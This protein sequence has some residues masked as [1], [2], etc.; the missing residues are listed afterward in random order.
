MHGKRFDIQFLRGVAVLAV[1][2][3]HA[4]KETFSRGFLGVDVFFV[5]SGFLITG[6]VLRG[7]EQG[8]FSFREFYLRRARRLLPASFA[9]LAVTTVLSV[10]LLTPAD[11][12]DYAKQLIGALTF[13]AN[14]VLAKQTGYFAAQAESK[15]LLHIWSLSLE[16]QFYFVAPLLLWL[17]PRRAWPWL[18]VC[19]AAGSAAGYFLLMGNS[20]LLGLRPNSAAKFAFFMLPTR[21]WELL[22]GSVVAWAMM[23]RP[24]AEAPVFA[25]YAALV[26]ICGTMLLGGRV[27]GPAGLEALLVTIAT[28]VTLVGGGEWLGRNKLTTSVAKIGDWSYS[29]YLVH[30]PLFAF[31]FILYLGDSPPVLLSLGLVLLSILLGWTQY[32]LVEQRFLVAR[33]LGRRAWLAIGGGAATLAASAI[34]MATSA[35]PAVGMEPQP[36]LSRSCDQ[37]G[38]I[39][40]DVPDC[41]IGRSPNVVL[42]GDSY[43]MH[44]VPGLRKAMGTDWE[45]VQA[46]KSACSPVLGLAHVKETYTRSWAEECAGFNQNVVAALAR[47]PSVR[48]VVLASSWVQIF[49]NSGQQLYVDGSV[50]PWSSR[51]ARDHLVETIRVVQATGSHVVIMGP[52]AIAPYDVGACNVRASSGR[53]V[54]RSG[55]CNPSLADVDDRIGAV[56]R[57]LRAAAVETG[58]TLLLPSSVMCPGEEC[59][60]VVDGKSVY[61]DRGHLTPYGSEYVIQH[62]SFRNA[63]ESAKPSQPPHGGG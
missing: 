12:A 52:T 36:G 5:I 48:S 3:Y 11:F 53:P 18:L 25:R 20:G 10:F 56:V 6:M 60:S 13:S 61:R 4:F 55:G 15:V 23:R 31:A 39:Y 29:I 9:T 37:R 63:L 42:W 8:T 58:A 21:A 50:Q 59:I 57:E 62:L 27:A 19:A 24:H 46:T 22:I 34:A 32:R 43:A 45:F 2:L 30:W 16:E 28:A 35:I 44:L 26:L 54:A 14:I 40:A 17:T 7:L 51:T 33:G 41:R 1:V 38:P 49:V 47:M